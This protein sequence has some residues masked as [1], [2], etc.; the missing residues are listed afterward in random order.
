VE[1]SEA[2]FAIATLPVQVNVSKFEVMLVSQS[3]PRYQLEGDQFHRGK[4]ED[5]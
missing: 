4:G 3:L 5:T 1:L 2:T